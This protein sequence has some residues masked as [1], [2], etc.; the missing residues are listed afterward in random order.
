LG[1][2]KVIQPIE[3]CATSSERAVFQNKWSK[4]IDGNWLTKIQ[5]K[6]GQD[7]KMVMVIMVLTI[8]CY[9][10]LPHDTMLTLY[11]L[12]SCVCL[13]QVGVLLKWLNVGSCKQC[14]TIAQ[15]LWFSVA[16][17]L[18]KTQTGSPQMEVPNAGGAG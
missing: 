10:F 3:S 5:L 4:K 15:G 17:D 8:T 16:I 13:S 9:Y 7:T 6:N 14:H 1:D 18:S 12:Q 11:M 2:R